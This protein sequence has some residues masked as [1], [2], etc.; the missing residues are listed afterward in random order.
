MATI[1]PGS[2]VLSVLGGT[3]N[4]GMGAIVTSTRDAA[5]GTGDV[6]LVAITRTFR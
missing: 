5:L 2:S 3:L 6:G 4:S 1:R